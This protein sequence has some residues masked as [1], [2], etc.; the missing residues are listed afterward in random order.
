M[1]EMSLRVVY[2]SMPFVCLE[3]QLSGESDVAVSAAASMT[4][5]SAVAALSPR[6]GPEDIFQRLQMFI[7]S[8]GEGTGAESAA[9]A[10]P[11]GAETDSLVAL[12]CVQPDRTTTRHSEPS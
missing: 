4:L 7:S 5:A 1:V 12:A 3:E 2:V 8:C 11:H 9:V 6:G 10:P